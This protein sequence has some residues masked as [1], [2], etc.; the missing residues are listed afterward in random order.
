MFHRLGVV[1]VLLLC[2]ASCNGGDGG[3]GE[4]AASD[5]PDYGFPECNVI[6]I[7]L[8][9]LR[10]DHLGCYG[11]PR[12]TSP[13]IDLFSKD[14]VLFESA[15]SHAPSTKP[16]HASVFTSMLVSHHGAMGGDANLSDDS[17]TMAEIMKKQGYTTVSYNG[18]GR[19]AS[20]YGF[21][22]GF[23]VYDE[24]YPNKFIKTVNAANQWLDDH[25]GEKFFMFLHTYEV[26]LPYNPAEKY[27]K[28]F[29]T[30]Y[31]G[32]LPNL[33]RESLVR[34]INEGK[35][36]ITEEDKQ[37]LVNLYD[38]S[39]RSLD[40]AFGAL[41]K[42]LVKR[43]LY[44]ESLII[45][46]SD[47]GEEF[48]ERGKVSE[49]S[50]SLYD[51][52]LKVVLLIKFPRGAFRSARVKDSVRLIDILPTVHDVLDIPIPPHFEGVSLIRKIGGDT[53]EGLFC[54]SE[55][56]NLK[57]RS[58]RTDRWKLYQTMLFDLEKDPSE[59]VDVSKEQK[60]VKNQLEAAMR[61]GI[62][63]RD[64]KRGKNVT[65]D[66]ETR[67]RLKELGYIK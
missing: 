4:Q 64:Q 41:I 35:R 43:D 58:I 8:D 16:S 66:D 11:Y 5:V 1:F 40:A 36:R 24:S 6:L 2:L 38:A 42:S 3:K 10:P 49:H 62:E 27:L 59:T 17:L 45:V 21:G 57:K 65:P 26:H 39:I 29:V 55:L 46:F 56:G 13:R 19:I 20:L 31:S 33:V 32:S 48:G 25:P 9:T 37:H 54:I 60:R 50:Y 67:A 44:D 7:S 52:L 22:Q 30:D 34:E 53:K 63:A 14:S 12:D 51:E 47:H 18:N 15:I 61:E 28:L 23:D